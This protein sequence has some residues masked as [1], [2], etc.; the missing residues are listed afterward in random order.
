MKALN[1]L[2]SALLLYAMIFTQY[3]AAD[4]SRKGFIPQNVTDQNPPD[5]NY[6]PLLNT[7]STSSRTLNATITDID[8]VPASGIGLPVLYWKINSGSWNASQSDL[9][10][11]NTYHFTF[12][13]GVVTADVVYYYV[14]AQDMASTPNV[15]SNPSGG[16]GGFTANPPAASTPPTF[17]NNY[18]IT[19]APLSG[20]I[21]VGL[22]FFN[23]ITGKNIYF[24]KVVKKVIKNVFAQEPDKNGKNNSGLLN[25][26]QKNVEVDEINWIPMENGKKYNGPLK[27][28]KSEHPEI[29]FPMNINGVYATLTSAVSDVNFRGVSGPTRL[30][31]TDVSYSIGETFPILFN[32]VNENAPTSTNTIS[33]K[34][35]TGMT[36]SISAASDYSS[37]FSLRTSYVIIDGSNT[38][39]GT[40]R[41]LTVS[42]T[43]TLSPIVITLVSS[44]TTPVVGSGIMNCFVINGLNTSSAITMTDNSF[45]AGFFNNN[46]IENNSIQKAYYG[47]YGTSQLA[48]G[49]GTGLNISNNELNSTGANAIRHIGIYVQGFN[50]AI[51]RGNDIANFENAS[52]EIDDGIWLDLGTKNVIIEKNK[53]YNLGYT[54]SNGY[55]SHG[56]KIQTGLTSANISVINNAIYNIYGLGF[57]YTTDL[58]NNPMGIF[59]LSSQSGLN[60][61]NNSIYLYGNTLIQNL[62]MSIGICLG[63]GTTANIRNNNIVNNLGLGGLYSYG[64]CAVYAQSDNTQ[65]SDINFNNYYVNPS[66]SG[67]KAIGKLS[68]TTTATTLSDWATATGKDEF[69]VSGDPGFTSTTN[70]HP[71]VNNV[72]C[73]NVNAGAM[74]L[75]SVSTDIDGNTRSTTV[76]GG[77]C[78]IGAYEFA[79]VVSP[80]NLTI[81]GN[82]ADGAS[83]VIYFAGSVL[84]TITWH[85]NGGTLP[86]SI[87]AVFQP[88]VNP[89]NVIPGSQYANEDFTITATGGSGF[90]YDI[91]NKYNLAR[92]GTISSEDLYRVAKYS[93]S[94]WT[95]YP[96]TPNMINKTVTVTDLNSFSTFA[97]G[98]GNAPLPVNFTSFNSSVNGR[99]VKL[100]WTTT[101]EITYM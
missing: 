13:S 66:G 90:L 10:N 57:D 64:A 21:T 34:P 28:L 60:V 38:T 9:V 47:V 30:L 23:K 73:W 6:T 1:I 67:T 17:P 74:P 22:N 79:P 51:I 19:Y 87:S 69:S 81:T 26:K 54:G 59:L 41:D 29:N 15:G 39:N 49:N 31:L 32:V 44:G 78:D 50:T 83:S 65:F 52:D 76:T 12:G 27:I 86:S 72:N 98:D 68:T 11:G 99:D 5:I 101:S 35:N 55:G 43:S 48:S 36:V 97:F 94:V 18:T 62:A 82:I 20:D 95:Q 2:F 7:N 91:V 45:S 77:A 63:S 80:G 56:I 89:P 25:V 33:V 53:I 70:L 75:S 4:L 96:S 14:V 16:A 100:Y 3:A 24:T 37:I 88:G 93:S 85:L 40:T 84:S 8:G 42:N 92:Q 61:Y 46:I 58:V 71:D